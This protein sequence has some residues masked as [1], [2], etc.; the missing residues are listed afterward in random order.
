MTK[1]TRL[2]RLA[3]D[4]QTQ[5]ADRLDDTRRSLVRLC[6][7][8]NSPSDKARGTPSY[9]HVPRCGAADALLPLVHQAPT[10]DALEGLWRERIVPEVLGWQPWGEG[11]SWASVVA[12]AEGADPDLAA[13]VDSL[14]LDS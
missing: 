11:R 7:G 14:G 6:L 2:D 1:R 10:Q 5:T 9:E 8:V 12:H 3:R 4:Q 13:Y